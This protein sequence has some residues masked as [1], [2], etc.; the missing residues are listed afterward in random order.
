MQCNKQNAMANNTWYSHPKFSL[1]GSVNEKILHF[2][3][4]FWLLGSCNIKI[5][6]IQKTEKPQNALRFLCVLQT[7]LI[8]H[9]NVGQSKST[10]SNLVMIYTNRTE[11]LCRLFLLK[12]HSLKIFIFW[13]KFWNLLTSSYQVSQKIT[14]LNLRALYINWTENWCRLIFTT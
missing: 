10:F 7:R 12:D 14:L 5:F 11:I 9:H 4:N 1:V 8:W 6:R 3:Q 13:E 2:V